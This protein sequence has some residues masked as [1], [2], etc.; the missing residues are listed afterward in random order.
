MFFKDKGIEPLLCWLTVNR[1]CNLRCRWCYAEGTDYRSDEMSLPLAQELAT[2]A[3]E[4]GTKG[5]LL[6]GGEP[7]LWESIF[8]FNHFCRHE[9]KIRTVLVTNGIQFGND[10]FWEKYQKDP[11]DNIGLSLKAWNPEHLKEVARSTAFDQMHEGMKRVCSHFNSQTSITYNTF[12]CGNLLKMAQFAVDCGSKGVKID[13]CSTTFVGQKPDSTYMVDPQ[14]LATNIIRDYPEL[15]RITGGKLTL[16]MM[17]PF[18]LFPREFIED[19]KAKNQITSVCQLK[20]GKGLIWSERGDLQMCNALFDYP[21]GHYGTDFTNAESLKQWLNSETVLG[22]YNKM[23]AYPSI[24]CQ[25]C[26]LYQDCGGGCPLRWA[27]YDPN[28]LVKPFKLKEN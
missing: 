2:V 27:I 20:K 7:T 23:G 13:F 4:V 5:I 21:I 17:I 1:N 14:Q 28:K 26:D 24:S 19:L 6:I 12:Y 10:E 22:Y 15:M 8:D 3:Q 25:S 16:E 9:R 18:C 11:N